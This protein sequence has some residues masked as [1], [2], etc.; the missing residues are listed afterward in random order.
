[1]N[2]YLKFANYMTSKLTILV[3][4]IMSSGMIQATQWS[5]FIATENRDDIIISFRQMKVGN[6]WLV[7]WQVNNKSKQ[8]IEPFLKYRHYLCDD[9]NTLKFSQSTL[10][11]YSPSSKR[12]G[13]LIDKKVCPNSKIKLV[14]I[15][16]E[17]KEYHDTTSTN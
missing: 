16:T 5:R 2:N 17:I 3:V 6:A 14:E 4:L 15:E 9:N 12:H 11:V 10:G 13:D 7:E 8:S 1:M